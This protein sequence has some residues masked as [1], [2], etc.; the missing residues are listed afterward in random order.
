VPVALA[1]G[2]ARGGKGMSGRD[3]ITA[4]VAGYEVALRVGLAATGSHFLR[5]YHFQ[6]TCGAFG[7]AATAAHVLG[8]DAERTRQALG[9]AGSQ[10]AGLMAA[11][12]GAMAKRMHGG[13]AAQSGVY[14]A[15]LAARGFTGIPNVLEA[16]YGGF[17]SAF[18][19]TAQ[20]AHLTEGYGAR[21]EILKVGYK[22]YASAASTHT[23]LHSLYV[24]MKEN[25]LKAADIGEIHLRCS[26]MA[27]RHCAWDYVPQGVTSAQMSLYYTL[28]AMAHDGEVL[29]EQFAEARLSAPRLLA[30]MRRI[31]IEADPQYDQGGDAT[32]HQSR[33][34]VTTTDGRRFE[35][36]APLRKGSPDFPMTTEERHAKFQ[37]LAT[38]ALSAQAIR[39]I[40][41]EVESLDAAAS[42]APLIALMKP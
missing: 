21:W 31:R 12:E 3:F 26:S 20:P 10:A 19:D 4:V 2:E 28:A 1:V 17:L 42:I 29:T 27:V 5:G 24:I 9:I 8:L 25:G 36:D 14:S 35:K 38:A 23:A 13:R 39:D 22:P 11:Q 40:I 30:F 34:T 41:R 7:A 33:M 15:L 37:R 18:T 16:P 32:R 6:G